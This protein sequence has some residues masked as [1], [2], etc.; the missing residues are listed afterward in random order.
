MNAKKRALKDT[1]AFESG[2]KKLN[3]KP[4]AVV[5]STYNSAHKK[6]TIKSTTVYYLRN[7]ESYCLVMICFER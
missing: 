3:K 7:M 6:V 1:E 4:K 5:T 2:G